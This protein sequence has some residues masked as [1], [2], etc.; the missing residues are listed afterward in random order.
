DVGGEEVE[1]F[2]AVDDVAGANGA[3]VGVTALVDGA[4]DL[5]TAEESLVVGGDIV[6]S[7]FS[8][9]LGD[10]ESALGGAE[11]ETEFGPLS[12]EFG[13]LNVF[14]VMGHAVIRLW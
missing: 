8:P 2:G 1:L 4:F 7:G 6:G 10:A 9:G 14:A 13:V 3:N 12:A 11:H 5:D